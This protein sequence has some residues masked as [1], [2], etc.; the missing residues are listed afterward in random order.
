MG[1]RRFIGV[2]ELRE[3]G[4]AGVPGSGVRRP[5]LAPL[6]LLARLLRGDIR[7]R[8]EQVSRGSP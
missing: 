8:V 6:L 2:G 3:E 5:S 7:A 1:R 4:A